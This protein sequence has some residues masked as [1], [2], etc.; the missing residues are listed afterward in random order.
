MVGGDAVEHGPDRHVV[1][2][3]AGQRDRRAAQFFDIRDCFAQRSGQARLRGDAAAGQIDRGAGHAQF[4]RDA[5]AD[6]PAGAG[7]QG[8]ATFQRA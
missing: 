4:D 1:G 7:Y 2:V 3:V 5:F 8:D 6:T